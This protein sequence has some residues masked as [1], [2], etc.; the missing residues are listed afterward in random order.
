MYSF[1][2][3][4]GN[5]TNLR[6]S[7]MGHVRILINFGAKCHHLGLWHQLKLTVRVSYAPVV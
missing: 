4:I 7:G 3:L 2:C 5:V 6:Y 1:G